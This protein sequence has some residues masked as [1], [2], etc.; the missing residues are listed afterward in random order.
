MFNRSGES[1]HPCLFP[2]F[3]RNGLFSSIKYNV[4]YRF[5]HILTLWCWATFLLFLVFLELLSWSGIGSY[6]RLLMHLLRWSSGFC[7]CF[8]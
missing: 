8:Y 3:R 1:G 4:G 2:D 7:L 5:C 6:Q